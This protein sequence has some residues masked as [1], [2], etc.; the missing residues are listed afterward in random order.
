M[1]KTQPIVQTKKMDCKKL[2][3]KYNKCLYVNTYNSQGGLNF[4]AGLI[5]EAECQPLE[6]ELFEKCNDFVKKQREV[7]G[8]LFSL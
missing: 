1:N 2:F 8:I 3:Y 4:D 5:V 6:A 7:N